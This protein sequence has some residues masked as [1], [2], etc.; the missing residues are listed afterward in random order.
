LSIA[1]NQRTSTLMKC[2]RRFNL[3]PNEPAA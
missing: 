1:R 2:R 3:Q